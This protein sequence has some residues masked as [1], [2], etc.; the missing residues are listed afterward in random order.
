MCVAD[1]G[2]DRSMAEN[3]DLKGL[4][5]WLVL[6]GIGVVIAPIHSLITYIPAYFQIFESG[7]WGALTEVSS[8]A[9]TPL[10]GEV[11][12]GEITFNTLMFFA[13]LLRK[14]IIKYIKLM[15]P[16]RHPCLVAAPL[17]GLA[18]WIGGWQN[19]ISMSKLS[20]RRSRCDE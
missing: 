18:L 12:I 4:K 19:H 20:A 14:M 9:Y 11:L 2:C 15:K 10:W 13:S 7:T 1:L 16:R 17:T 3:T 8:Q 5:G 6:V